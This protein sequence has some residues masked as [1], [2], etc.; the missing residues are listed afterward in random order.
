[1][2]LLASILLPLLALSARMPAA[3]PAPW[4]TVTLLAP[5]DVEWSG[6]FADALKKGVARL[7]AEP[8]TAEWLLA[9]VSFKMDRIFTNYSG[10]ASGRFIELAALTSQ[11]G[12]PS[13]AAL[14][15]VLAQIAS[16]QKA[17]GHFGVEVDLK[18]PLAKA[19]APIP[20]L[21]GNARLLV[22]LVTAARET[23]DAGLLAAARKLGDFYVASAGD[24]S[25]PS[26]EADYR[27]SGTYGDGYTCC[28]FPAIESLALLHRATG[29]ARYLEQ[30]RRMADLFFRMDVLPVD[31]SHGNLCAWRGVLELFG[32]TGER[33]YLERA[34]AKWEAAMAGGFVWPLGGIGEHWMVFFEGDEG[35]SESDW[36]R[37][38]LDLWRYTGET[39]YLDVAERL[40]WNQYLENQTPNGGYGMRHFDGDGAGPLATRGAVDEWPFCCSFHGPLG[41]HFLEGYLAAVSEQGVFVN[42]P[43]DFT[44]PLKIAG[45]PAVLS[46]RTERDRSGGPVL[47]IELAPRDGPA[48]LRTALRLRMP[49]WADRAV[50]IRNGSPRPLEAKGGYLVFEREFRTGEKIA[51][52]L[53]RKGLRI[54]DRRMREV[55]AS[56]GEVTRLREVCLA[57]GPDIL[58]AIPSP[59][60][61]RP[62]LIV[63][64]GRGGIELLAPPVPATAEAPSVDL[65]N[66]RLV[67]LIAASRPVS[68]RPLREIRSR[69]R[70]AFVFDL[71]VAPESRIA[72]AEDRFAKRAGEAATAAQGPY[73]GD[74]LE[75]SADLWNG[76]AGWK[77]APEGLLVSGGDVGL[78]DG[79][80]YQDYRYEFDLTLPAEGQ[81]ISG[82]VARAQSGGD[83]LMFQ[84]QSADSTLDAPEF[85]TRPNTLRPHVRRHGAWEIA[86]PVPL[87]REVRRGE[88]HRVAIECRGDKVEVF[89]DGQR[90]WSGG[91]SGLRSGPVGFRAS[92][93]AEQGLFR[94]VSLRK[95]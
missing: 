94:N 11:P 46:V 27:S 92:G 75:K 72:P 58:G 84:I 95:L 57:A 37:F 13:P 38:N 79:E 25:S 49:S 78:L 28:Y 45:R 93:P 22:G 9:D 29:E 2:K 65:A 68:V 76:S 77:F 35:C 66:D 39:R 33:A 4:P 6:P 42:F 89:I 47:E 86:D 85:K 23:G 32:S 82:W 83:C 41:L 87:S 55:Q 51:V 10:D 44:A 48:P 43:F 30:A 90:A 64:L 16:F 1:M 19:S 74:G 8:F 7:A 56:A 53:G 14:A 62:T 91:D 88:T 40:L 69:R 50:E 5:R 73:F 59:A 52:A 26:R 24:L 61:G 34:R 15:P 20:M 80:G 17:D 60:S 54:E 71:I 36:L 3:E 63:K 67:D 12:H 31:H 18:K 21:W 70:A 81:G